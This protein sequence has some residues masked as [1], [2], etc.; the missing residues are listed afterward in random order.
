MQRYATQNGITFTLL[1][2][3][4]LEVI[5]AWGLVNPD[6]PSVPHPTAVVVDGEGLIRYFRQDV[7][8]TIR[9]PSAELLDAVDQLAEN[10]G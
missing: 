9:P 10:S 7:D 6:N 4:N 3:G 8:F 1:S 2:D 5:K